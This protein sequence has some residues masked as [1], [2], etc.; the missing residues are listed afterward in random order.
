VCGCFAFSC[1]NL[2]HVTCSSSSSSFF[3]SCQQPAPWPATGSSG[4]PAAA[5]LALAAAS[6]LPLV[7]T[8]SAPRRPARSPRPAVGVLHRHVKLCFACDA[9]TSVFFVFFSSIFRTATCSNSNWT[10]FNPCD[11]TGRQRW[12]TVQNLND[13]GVCTP[14]IVSELQ[15]CSTFSDCCR[16]GVPFFVVSFLMVLSVSLPPFPGI[17]P[18]PSEW[19][20]WSACSGGSRTQTRNV[21]SLVQD[22]VCVQWTEQLSQQC[23][24]YD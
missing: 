24:T 6:S 19:S 10:E 11:G 16:V 14:A 4:Q 18:A 23:G 21:F 5:T 3:L 13:A 8:A 22:G 9:H 1:Y 2:F 12:R 7:T 20:A 17:C 15:K